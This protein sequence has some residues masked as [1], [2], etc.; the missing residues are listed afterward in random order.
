MAAST[1]SAGNIL[2]RAYAPTSTSLQTDLDMLHSMVE[3]VSE[4]RPITG[5]GAAVGG[6]LDWKT[7]VGFS[8][9]PT[10]LAKRAS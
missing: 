9:S 4:G 8:P 2:K 6:P 1:D 7:G 3:E 5:M 10:R